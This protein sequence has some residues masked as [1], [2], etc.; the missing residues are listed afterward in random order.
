MAIRCILFDL[1]GTL[2]QYDAGRVGQDFSQTYELVQSAGASLTYEALLS[3]IDQ[4][5]SELDDW[6]ASHGRE[7]SMQTVASELFNTLEVSAE[8]HLQEQSLQ[9]QFAETYT[10]EWSKAVVPVHGVQALLQR[11]ARQFTTGVIT[12]THYEPMVLRLISEHRFSGLSTVTTS[13]SHCSPKPQPDIFLDT[14]KT[15]GMKPS[16]CVYVGDNCTA[17]YLGATAVGMQCYLIGKHAR[18]PRENQIPT[19]MDLPLHLLK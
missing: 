11:C 13:V 18:V 16:E 10:L 6:S 15:L 7:Y 1:F 19:V 4:V 3:S 17:D 14:L 8:P 12:N 2:V 5:F 9:N